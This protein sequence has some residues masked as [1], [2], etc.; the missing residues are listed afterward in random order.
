MRLENSYCQTYR[1]RPSTTL[2]GRVKREKVIFFRSF[3]Q[4]TNLIPS[5]IFSTTC[6]F[7][8]SCAGLHATIECS[9][10]IHCQTYRFQ[11]SRTLGGGV[12]KAFS[13]FFVSFGLKTNLI[14][15][16]SECDMSPGYTLVNFLGAPGS[17][18]KYHLTP[19]RDNSRLLQF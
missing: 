16:R 2:G 10:K 17:K 4:K 15:L 9:S 3:G 13:V 19:S 1:F 14:P 7:R 8:R 5:S 11:P 12:R 6:L 18:R